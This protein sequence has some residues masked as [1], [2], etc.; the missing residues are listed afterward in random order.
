MMWLDA[1]A[2]RAA[3]VK[4]GLCGTLNAKTR[5]LNGFL[6]IMRSHWNV[7]KTVVTFSSILKLG[8]F[9]QHWAFCQALRV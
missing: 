2:G 6:S 3:W 8:A 9:T 1:G 5:T 4:R 7:L